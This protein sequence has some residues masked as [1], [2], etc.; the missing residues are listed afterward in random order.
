MNEQIIHAQPPR[1]PEE[2]FK[3]VARNAEK[4]PKAKLIL[5]FD[6]EAKATVC[7]FA[8]SGQINFWSV[9]SPTTEDQARELLIG[10]LQRGKLT[11]DQI[12]FLNMREISQLEA[13]DGEP[14]I[15]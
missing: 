9:R 3:V 4:Y 10:E 5:M 13:D 6:P 2:I 14:T 1:L 7:G 12:V 8:I 15:N 11:E